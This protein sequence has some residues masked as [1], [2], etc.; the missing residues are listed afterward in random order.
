MR[1]YIIWI[2]AFLLLIN[3]TPK[4]STS[5]STPSFNHAYPLIHTVY[6]EVDEEH[7]KQLINELSKMSAI[8][9]V[10]NLMIGKFED[11]GDKR[12][13]SNYVI[14]MQMQFCD[15]QAYKIYQAHKIH[16]NLKKEVKSILN[17]APATH[18]F[19]LKNVY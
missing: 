4:S 2:G 14:V 13:L 5:L 8:K 18:D 16:Q 17:A 6:F 11:L 12:A 3:C 9:E 10:N 15:Q 19:M 7:Q 1:N